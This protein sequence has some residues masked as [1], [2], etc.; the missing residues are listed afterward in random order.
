MTLAGALLR[1]DIV[2]L[3]HYI[4][5]RLPDGAVAVDIYR[6]LKSFRQPA[7]ITVNPMVTAA[8]SSVE[9]KFWSEVLQKAAEVADCLNRRAE[10]D[11]FI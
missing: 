6:P 10:E 3:E 2:E 9:A 1:Y 4:E 7:F 8:M 11:A 5:I